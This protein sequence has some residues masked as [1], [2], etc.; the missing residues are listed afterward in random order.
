MYCAMKSDNDG[1][2][3]QLPSAFLH[4]F[5][6]SVWPTGK[7]FLPCSGGRSYWVKGFLHD[8]DVEI[9][10][11]APSFRYIAPSH[12]YL[13]ALG[14]RLQWMM[15]VVVIASILQYYWYYLNTH[16]SFVADMLIAFGVREVS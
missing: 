12:Q 8:I 14:S 7:Y 2:P 5:E 11:I 10:S 9:E 1:L 15:Q 6:R 4:H 13:V 3:D 16:R